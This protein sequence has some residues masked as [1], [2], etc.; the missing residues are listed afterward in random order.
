MNKA[1]LFFV[2]H[3]QRI[4]HVDQS[5]AL[6]SPTPQDPPLTALGQEQSR[7]TGAALAVLLFPHER[8]SSEIKEEQTER[9]DSRM[10]PPESPEAE[11]GQQHLLPLPRRQHHVAIVTS[12]F[13]RCT[14]TA[15]E[16]AKGLRSQTK[17]CL[18]TIAV[19][20]GLAEWLSFEYVSQ[21]VPDSM[22]VQRMQEFAITR[23]ENEQYFSVDWKY[24]AHTITL[25]SWPEAREAMQS[26]VESAYR[27]VLMT[28]L[29]SSAPVTTDRD[30]SIVFVSHASPV[31]A[32]LESCLQTPTLVPIASCSISQC[33]WISEQEYEA[34]EQARNPMVALAS[35]P[36]GAITTSISTA[37]ASNTLGS[38]TSV[39]KVSPA[40]TVSGQYGRWR[41]ALQGSV[42]HLA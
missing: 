13:L 5:W 35:P 22:I 12:P 27:H 9:N 32:L 29:G 17:D 7:K 33:T 14:Q 38:L 20:P 42:T 3:G 16:L 1:S 36:L 30:I 40:I 41:L 25:P 28:Y 26:R 2:R 11:Q 34:E 24:R 23:R 8:A 21:P 10:T 19:E 37:A 18:I 4:D 39:P 15:A 6:S 31:N